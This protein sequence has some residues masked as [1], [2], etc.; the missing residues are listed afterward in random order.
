VPTDPTKP[1]P[2]AQHGATPRNNKKIAD[3][4]PEPFPLPDNDLSTKQ[5]T[6]V[7]LLLRG[8][9]DAQIAAQLGIDR[10]TVYRWRTRH[11]A[12]IDELERQRQVLWQQATQRLQAMFQPALDILQNQ[13]TGDDP[14]LALRA[15]A[16][17]LRF[18]TP[19]RLA[20][21]TREPTA[22]SAPPPGDRPPRRDPFDDFLE[23]YLNAPLPGDAGRAC[24]ANAPDVPKWGDEL[25]DDEE[26]DELDE[27][28]GGEGDGD[29]A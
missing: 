5:R 19:A 29:D 9:G 8:L 11:D 6:A 12:F 17:L 23:A 20:R 28:D 15:A 16:L 10:G 24:D 18:A 21:L 26:G 2:A 22:P 27:D 13:L 4:D 7:E 1:S 25:D 14:R 3:P